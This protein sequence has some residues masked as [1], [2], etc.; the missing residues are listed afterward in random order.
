MEELEIRDIGANNPFSMKDGII[1]KTNGQLY[2]FGLT[3][4]ITQYN[5]H[6]KVTPRKYK[7]HR[8]LH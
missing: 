8:S 4:F 3:T 7:V 5:Y 1:F 2:L 6:Y